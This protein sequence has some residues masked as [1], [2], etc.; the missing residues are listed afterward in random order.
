[1]NFLEIK[2]MQQYT[3]EFEELSSKVCLNYLVLKDA[4]NYARKYLTTDQNIR[5]NKKIEELRKLHDD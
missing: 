3:K 2:K 5:L 1:M 4:L